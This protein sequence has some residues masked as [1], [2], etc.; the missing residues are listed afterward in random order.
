MQLPEIE[1]RVDWPE[2]VAMAQAAEGVGFD[3]LW[4]GDH[5]LYD[6]PD[7]TVRGPWEAWT[8]LAGLAA[9]TSRIEL[10]PLVAATAFHNPAMLA[11][12]AATVD[13]ISGGRLIVGLGAGWN[14][15][16]FSAYG[17][18]YDHRVGRFE[19]AF[20]IVRSLLRDGHV[21]FRGQYHQAV[22]CTLDP[23][24]VRPGGPPLLLGSTGP[25]MLSIALPHVDAWNIWWFNY[26]NTPEGFAAVRKQVEEAAVAAGRA[27]GEVSATAATM[28]R[29]PGGVGRPRGKTPPIEGTPS[30]IAEH[31]TALAQAGAEHVQIVV[32]PITVESIEWL[33]QA[34]TILDE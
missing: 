14:E 12:Q 19:E 31:I 4:V 32:D 11:K 6:M 10:G 15:R 7:G 29:L 16:E 1:R 18:P 26:G 13:A 28:I 27:P 33:G 9:V 20:T 24:P 21:D 22:D 2:L 34:L 25:R 23:P 3:S 5:L 17:L 8:S 30:D